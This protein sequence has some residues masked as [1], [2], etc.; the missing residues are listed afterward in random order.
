[1][2]L[3]IRH[4]SSLECIQFGE[5]IVYSAAHIYIFTWMKERR[6]RQMHKLYLQLPEHR[7]HFEREHQLHHQLQPCLQVLFQYPIL[8][9]CWGPVGELPLWMWRCI[10][11][12]LNLLQTWCWGPRQVGHEYL[13]DGECTRVSCLLAGA[14]VGHELHA[15]VAACSRVGV[16]IAFVFVLIFLDFFLNLFNWSQKVAS[17]NHWVEW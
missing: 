14:G 4:G 15:R 1:M 8:Q 9:E 17:C 3:F 12:L 5:V 16:K 10:S 6:D 13:L 2:F 11:N 7:L